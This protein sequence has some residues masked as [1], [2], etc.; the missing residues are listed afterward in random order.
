MRTIGE[1]TRGGHRGGYRGRGR[2]GRG[3]GRQ[4]GEDKRFVSRFTDPRFQTSNSG[5]GGRGGRP[6]RGGRN[7]GAGDA[8]TQD[9]R[10]AKYFAEQEPQEN[11][12]EDSEEVEE[13]AEE[14]DGSGSDVAL[15]DDEAAALDE[16]AQAWSGSED[17]EFCEAR[18]RVAIVNCDW[19]HVR[20]VDL[21]A[22]LFHA[23]PL[24]GQLKDVKIY[25]SDFGKERLENERMHGPDLWVKPGE[26]DS[27][28]P[29]L[30]EPQVEELKD[31]EE[32]QYSDES[33]NGS[34][35]DDGWEDDNPNMMEEE[36][37]DGE[38]FSSGKY[39]KYERDRLKYYYAIATFD[40]PD[41]AAA[42]YAD[43]DGMDI[44][45]SGVVLD[46]R[47]VDD[48]ES[49]GKPVQEASKIPPN[50]RPLS[51][52][53]A[54][55]MSQTKFRIS[56]DQDDVHRHHSIRD[57]FTGVTED[58]DLGAYIAPNSSSEEDFELD[59][60][61]EL[62]KAKRE[63][64][65]RKLRQRYAA[66]LSE[67]GGIPDQ[68]PEEDDGNEDNVN[69]EGS[70][71]DDDLNRF[72]DVDEEDSDEESDE[73]SVNGNVEGTFD[74][75]ADTKASR[76]QR[77]AAIKKALREG[78][79]GSQTQ[80]KY[81]LQRKENK[82]SK[83]E[84]L[85]AERAAE[86]AALEA[87]ASMRKKALKKAIGDQSGDDQ[88]ALSG[89]EKRKIHAKATKERLAKERDDKKKMRLANSLGVEK[90]SIRP[91]KETAEAVEE[92]TIDSRFKSKL[93]SDPRFHLDVAQRD[94]RTNADVVKLASRVVKERQE[95]AKSATSRK[96]TER[97]ATTTPDEA[98]DF[99]LSRPSKK[100]RR[101]S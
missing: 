44:E 94:K 97:S 27:V 93:M 68:I 70:S 89:K 16:D 66:L 52:F 9:P 34:D 99:F 74:F 60:T 90:D 62:R 77:D 28:A 100:P 14:Q 15:S 72:S 67:I 36:G 61:A 25:L 48:D 40:S 96:T 78:D 18:R 54:A 81:K 4:H 29:E 84:M 88:E 79:I 35:D 83:K 82:K 76:L 71:D 91:H 1:S 101:E 41:T 56:W 5:R 45:A 23:L 87:Q 42:V 69:D 24:G 26:A 59:P 11:D 58:D 33:D 6:Q 98:A 3:G 46:L 95:A 32:N 64:K 38:K 37:D 80:L 8:A 30:A 12:D 57:S 75:D 47:Y 19:D 7:Q 31:D 85:L 86:R 43:L 21:Y 53:K 17:L 55:A 51:S 13:G 2:G 20:A 65:K 50:F 49:F 10:F 73:E 39:R 63:E 22:I 92:T